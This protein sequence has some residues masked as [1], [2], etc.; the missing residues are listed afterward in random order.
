VNASSVKTRLTI[1]NEEPHETGRAVK[2]RVKNDTDLDPT[3]TVPPGAARSVT[4]YR[5]SHL[6]IIED[7]PAEDAVRRKFGVA[8]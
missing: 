2:V 8:A 6:E 1:I 3:I 5:G 7:D 4:L